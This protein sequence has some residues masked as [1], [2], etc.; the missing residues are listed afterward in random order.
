MFSFIRQL[1]RFHYKREF[2]SATALCLLIPLISLA[3]LIVLPEYHLLHIIIGIST[4]LTVII[5]VTFLYKRLLFPLGKSVTEL[6]DNYTS[7]LSGFTIIE[8]FNKIL[9]GYR[10]TCEKE[11][12]RLIL[13]KQAEIEC[14]Q[15]QIKPHFLYNTLDSICGQAL[16]EDAR[17][18]YDMVESLSHLL[19]YSISHNNDMITIREE[20]D[21]V[22]NYMNILYYRF[23][24]RYNLH[25]H[26]DTE[27]ELILKYKI[28]KLTVQPLIENAIYHG[29]ENCITGGLIEVD[30]T[31]TQSRILISVSDNGVGIPEE[32]LLQINRNLS[33]A[34]RNEPNASFPDSLNGSGQA[35][36]NVNSR[37][38]LIYG[39]KY[40]LT[41]YSA[42]NVGTR[43]E[44]I[45]PILEDSY[46]I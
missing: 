3:I 33:T 39:E 26:I 9:D 11:Y 14:M 24:D 4:C 13:Q 44:I 6:N 37:I 2:F 15:S 7:D 38:K 8:S 16:Q 42:H 43:A 10:S 21:C 30:V 34:L 28:P 40:G 12:S 46:E 29:L 27:D 17:R 22:R 31:M 1:C 5:C 36:R 35:L 19:R 32:Q 41:L 45:L 20:L 25:I 23:A 18:T